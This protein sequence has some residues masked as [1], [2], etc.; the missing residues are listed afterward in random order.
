MSINIDFSIQLSYPQATI[1]CHLDLNDNHQLVS[2]VKSLASLTVLETLSRNFQ[3]KAKHSLFAFLYGW[4]SP[5]LTSWRMMIVSDANAMS[6]SLWRNDSG[7]CSML[8][9]VYSCSSLSRCSSLA[10]LATLQRPLNISAL[11]LVVPEN[12][13]KVPKI[14]ITESYGNNFSSKREKEFHMPAF[15]V[16]QVGSGSTSLHEPSPAQQLSGKH[17]KA[18]NQSL[19]IYFKQALNHEFNRNPNSKIHFPAKPLPTYTPRRP[20]QAS[21]YTP[22]YASSL[23]CPPVYIPIKAKPSTSTLGSRPSLNSP[24]QYTCHT[25][26][27]KPRCGLPSRPRN[28]DE[29]DESYNLFRRGE[30]MELDGNGS[31]NRKGEWCWGC[32]YVGSWLNRDQD[33]AGFYIFWVARV[34]S[35]VILGRK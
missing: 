33:G 30:N 23:S 10:A 15:P 18:Q 26:E 25:V 28:D 29:G 4:I 9:S 21:G 16:L 27:P 2:H 8:G 22:P 32:C 3:T 1:P 34:E 17:L 19:S 7:V 6:R 12:S 5:K 35:R 11:F 13:L 24:P 20:S 31:R 14:R